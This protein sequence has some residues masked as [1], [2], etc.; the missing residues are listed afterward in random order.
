MDI[1]DQIAK[2]NHAICDF[3][4]MSPAE[5]VNRGINSKF[6]ISKKNPPLS[7][8]IRHWLSFLCPGHYQL[9]QTKLDAVERRI[10][11]LSKAATPTQQ[12]RLN[13]IREQLKKLS[14]EGKLAE[15]P[16]AGGTTETKG[17][18]V[19]LKGDLVN[20]SEKIKENHVKKKASEMNNLDYVFAFALANQ[21]KEIDFFQKMG[22]TTENLTRPC[23]E[24]KDDD[25]AGYNNG[26]FNAM[27][28]CYFDREDSIGIGQG[29]TYGKGI[30]T[31]HPMAYFPVISAATKPK[32]TFEI[33]QLA[34]L[35]FKSCE[36]TEEQR[37]Q[38]LFI[39]IFCQNGN[40][41]HVMFMVIE[42]TS[43]DTARITTVN[44]STGLCGFD[45]F[46]KEAI[47]AAKEAFPNPK[48]TVVS[49]KNHIFSTNRS[50]GV[51]VIS[52]M[53]SFMGVP[54][55]QEVVAKG[56]KGKTPSEYQ[57]ERLQQAEDL[58]RFYSNNWGKT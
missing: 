45:P 13:E 8:F 32:G 34:L 27:L 46:E 42:C 51:D 1:D 9:A 18:L 58:Y 53:K 30:N 43:P 44:T 3:Q 41:A 23:H 57:R 28:A 36:L 54:N 17:D 6:S 7:E 24:L 19:N 49:N 11:K 47:R 33:I 29:E 50:C 22:L 56:L 39:P 2:A 38:K 25:T 10:L 14:V 5:R 48:T 4:K 35:H 16:G 21:T 31:T 52:L 12:K 55:V 20:L 37:P 26:I 15:R 40:V